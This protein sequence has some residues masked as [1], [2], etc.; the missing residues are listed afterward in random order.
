M[1]DSNSVRL[2]SYVSVLLRLRR[3]HGAQ[4]VARQQARP[5]GDAAAQ[6]ALHLGEGLKVDLVQRSHWRVV[7][8]AGSGAQMGCS[9]LTTV[10][11]SVSSAALGAGVRAFVAFP[12]S[13]P[14][15]ACGHGRPTTA[16]GGL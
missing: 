6:F 5:G 9:S 10:K 2:A 8:S 4:V 14:P 12:R 3:E 16:A 11:V 1:Q 7:M 15:P 13:P